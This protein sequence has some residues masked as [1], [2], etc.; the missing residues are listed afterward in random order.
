[1]SK[2]GKDTTGGKTGTWRQDKTE[3]G[4]KH[5]RPVSH[6]GGNQSMISTTDDQD[7]WYDPDA[8]K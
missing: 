5:S 1:M 3:A 7:A 4:W 6:G 8:G 2:P